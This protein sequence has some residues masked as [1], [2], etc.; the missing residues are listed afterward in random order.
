M[1]RILGIFFVLI[2]VKEIRGA[3]NDVTT[4]YKFH[5][6]ES[7]SN[8]E[9]Y[10]NTCSVSVHVDNNKLQLPLINMYGDSLLPNTTIP[11]LYTDQGASTWFQMTN[12]NTTL[13]LPEIHF[14]KTHFSNMHI[15]EKIRNSYAMDTIEEKT[16]SAQGFNE[17]LL[18]ENKEFLK[19]RKN[20]R[21]FIQVAFH[22]PLGF[23]IS[24]YWVDRQ[25]IQISFSENT[26]E[27]TICLVNQYIIDFTT[28]SKAPQR[29]A[30]NENSISYI[31]I[32]ITDNITVTDLV[33]SVTYRTPFHVPEEYTG[34]TK[35]S[36]N[37]HSSQSSEVS[38]KVKQQ[39]SV[40]LVSPWIEG[41]YNQSLFVLYSGQETSNLS[42]YIEDKNTSHQIQLDYEEVNRVKNTD[43]VNIVLTKVNLVSTNNWM[44]QQRIKIIA[45]GDVAIVNV[46][47]GRRLDLY[48]IQDPQPCVKSNIRD[49]YNTLDHHTM[50]QSDKMSH[51]FNGGRLENDFICSCPPGF[52]GHACQ[53]PCGRNLFGQ[54]CGK[55]CSRSPSACKG[56]V[57]CTP[58]Y[59]CSCAPGYQGDY[60]SEQCQTDFFR[61]A[62]GKCI[63][64]KHVCDR[65]KHCEDNSDELNRVYCSRQERYESLDNKVDES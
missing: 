7:D 38:F 60:C 54:K 11:S 12:N 25:G 65:D 9:Q 41:V 46:W 55:Q 63:P 61:C 64:M 30:S 34:Y 3:L 62:N 23:Y 8:D 36:H 39:T 31:A 50:A 10:F 13:F 47:E 52:V 20:T 33:A 2:C 5:R 26:R 21:T 14:D 18:F 28:C 37:E 48:R 17:V 51:C 19:I 58:E 56:V 49:V 59:G 53:I 27:I 24:L 1:S 44:D 16:A 43:D 15:I 4:M 29:Y 57:L 6:L 32:D 22:A 45:S 35:I 42:V 40:T